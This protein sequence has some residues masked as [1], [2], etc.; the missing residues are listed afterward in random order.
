MSRPPDAQAE[1]LLSPASVSVTLPAGC[2]KTELIASMAVCAQRQSRRL[3]ILTHTNAGAEV[4]RR[5]LARHEVPQRSA[6]VQT[7]DG[8]CRY[9]SSQFPSVAAVSAEPENPYL[10]NC[11]GA[12]RVLSHAHVREL[13]ARTYDRVV[14]DEYQDT[15]LTQHAVILAMKDAL[16]ITVFGDPLQGIYEWSGN[17]IVDWTS[18]V[19]TNF[20]EVT[21][22]ARPWR[23]KGYN[24]GL[25][26]WLIAIRND[27]HSGRPIYLSNSSDLDWKPRSPA[28][29]RSAS[30][31]EMSSTGT[32]AILHNQPQ[33]CYRFA[34]GMG[35][36]YGVMEELECGV[37]K[38]LAVELDRGSG[39]AAASAI[40]KFV[41]ECASGWTAPL[42]NAQIGKLGR[43][44]RPTP[45]AGSK[46]SSALHALSAV[47]DSVEASTVMNALTELERVTDV[48]IF[49]REAW[50]AACR[51]V[52]LASHSPG[53]TFSDCAVAVRNRARIAGRSGER[54][55]V[56]R[57]LL[58]KGL[59]YD[60]CVVLDADS[61]SVRNLYV[62]L[63][64]AR[65]KLVVI[66]E[67]PVL[68]PSKF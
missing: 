58:V 51:T 68:S 21:V 31:A 22:E 47:L 23:W 67:R 42:D 55:V 24:E 60:T 57:T 32:V 11:E 8:F 26:E 15:S 30:L 49:R 39:P 45:R 13:V 43:G 18:D 41:R 48:K 1:L 3:L 14:V 50:N 17:A 36:R 2:G 62:A 52:E 54:R 9:L 6:V 7:I 44:I 53:R 20:K 37:L 35:G 61:M 27:L 59:E 56:S 10:A 16:G 46:A 65:Q 34:R 25:G 29:Q 63:T 40:L 5:R 64:R 12:A 66:S 4:I 38:R 19:L 33:Q 28:T